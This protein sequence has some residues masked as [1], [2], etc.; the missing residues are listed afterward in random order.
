MPEP[1]ISCLLVDDHE[2]LRV[3][4]ARGLSTFGWRCLQAAHGVQALELLE[5]D[6]VDIVISDIRMPEMDGV[7]LLD[8]LREH[9]PDVAV[10][11][12]TGVT[13][14]SVRRIQSPL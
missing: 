13:D 4:V 11:M 1:L 3:A 7:T 10:I 2:G 14:V 9:H 5:G 6:A 8:A 12:V